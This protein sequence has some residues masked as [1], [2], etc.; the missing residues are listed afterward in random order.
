MND[1]HSTLDLYEE[2][3]VTWGEREFIIYGHPSK[4]DFSDPNVPEDKTVIFEPQS[5]K[6][7]TAELAGTHLY[8]NRVFGKFFKLNYQQ[9]QESL[10]MFEEFVKS[11]N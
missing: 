6:P 10:K 3:H 11:K 9:Q 7:T 5:G 1:A 4:A 8:P 2:K